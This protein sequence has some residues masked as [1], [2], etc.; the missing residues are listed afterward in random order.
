MAGEKGDHIPVF[1]NQDLLHI[2]WS[3]DLRIGN[4]VGHF[5]PEVCDDDFITGL[6]F[7][8]IAEIGSAAPAS[9]TGN[10]TVCIVAADG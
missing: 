5:S 4:G 8:D 2:V 9:V 7:R 10:H 3:D 6:Q 1:L